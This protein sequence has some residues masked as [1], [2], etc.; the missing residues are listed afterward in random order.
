MKLLKINKYSD[1]LVIEFMD[2]VYALSSTVY[3]SGFK[4]LTHVV[5]KKVDEDFNV[6]NPREYSKNFIAEIGL[7]TDSTA[8]FLT[9]VDVAKEYIYRSINKPL[10][11]SIVATLGFSH[12]TCIDEKYEKYSP[13]TINILVVIDSKLTENA[14]IDLVSVVN[15]VKTLAFSDTLLSCDNN[16]KAFATVTD[17]LIISSYQRGVLLKY[18]GAGTLIGSNIAKMIYEIVLRGIS[19]KLSIRDRFRYVFGIDI[20]YLKE[21]VLRIYR[22]SPIP[23]II[24]KDVEK[25]VDRVLE[26]LLTDPNIWAL[27]LA[28]KELDYKG[29]VGAIPNLSIEEYNSDTTKIVADE[30]LGIA[31]STYI[32]GWKGMFTY[33]WIDRIKDEIKEFKKLPMFT[34][35]LLGS[36]IGGILSKIYDRFLHGVKT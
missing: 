23:N 27:G 7:P 13:S 21:L 1:Y 33:Y 28:F 16:R 18:G 12:Y 20:D 6:N 35:D 2:K 25:E 4:I 9:A 14:F 22:E 26:G 34:D 24:L 8:V 19:N 3:G 11:I 31:L 32:N 30:I 15:S 10:P 5:F 17:A 36:L 29:S